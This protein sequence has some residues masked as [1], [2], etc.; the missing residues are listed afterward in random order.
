MDLDDFLGPRL[1]V[2]DLRS[3]SKRE[4]I[5]ELIA[6]LVAAQKMTAEHKDKISTVVHKRESAMS[7]GIGFG[8]ALPHAATDLV[9]DV[10]WVVGRSKKGIQFDAPDGKPVNLVMLFLVPTGQ[11]QMH[12]NTLA[13]IAKF[14]HRED[15][16]DGLRHR[17]M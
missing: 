10:V 6:H 9:A 16:R 14:L 1:I 12:A 3:E 15:F 13:N 5:E 4:A 17:F 8:I 11:F 2:V 7:T